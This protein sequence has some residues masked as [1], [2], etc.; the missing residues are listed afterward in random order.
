MRIVKTGEIKVSDYRK[1]NITVEK[2]SEKAIQVKVVETAVVI[3]E[4][5]VRERTEWLPKSQ[6][7]I[8]GEFIVTPQ[9]L[10]R[11]KGLPTVDIVC[12]L[13]DKQLI[14]KYGITLPELTD[15]VR[16]KLLQNGDGFIPK[17]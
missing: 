15:S 11:K 3:D 14:E 17:N 16:V 6:I 2:E 9:W 12:K 10:V 13:N 7:E 5:E 8:I 4:T 1:Y